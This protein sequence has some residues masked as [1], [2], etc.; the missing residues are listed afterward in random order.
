MSSI[1]IPSSLNNIIG[2][3]LRQVATLPGYNHLVFDIVPTNDQFRSRFAYEITNGT[4]A[5]I[6]GITNVVGHRVTS[7]E[8]GPFDTATG[9]ASLIL[10]SDKPVGPNYM[11]IFI[12]APFAQ[13]E[14]F[15]L[16]DDGSYLELD[17]GDLLL[18]DEYQEADTQVVLDDEVFKERFPDKKRERDGLQI[19]QLNQDVTL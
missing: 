3:R 14:Y 4:L 10:R 12:S 7:V 15:L 13:E 19:I 18:L 11:V 6:S 1:V 2:F 17:E 9:N 5:R 8:S 16:L